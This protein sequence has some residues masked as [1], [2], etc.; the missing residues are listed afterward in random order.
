MQRRADEPAGD[1]DL[2]AFEYVF[3]KGDA[4]LG[5][6]TE[7]LRQR[8]DQT[9]G[10]RGRLDRRAVGQVLVLRWMDATVDVPDL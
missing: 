1:S 3:A 10:Q 9:L 4:G 2:L 5:R 7:M 6:S 8:Q